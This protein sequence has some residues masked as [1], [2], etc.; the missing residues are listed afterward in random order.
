PAHHFMNFKVIDEHGRQLDMGR[1][2]G[3]LRAELGGQARESFQ[4]LA[5]KTAQASEQGGKS[6]AAPSRAASGNAA[7]SSNAQHQNL[8]GWTF[9]ELPELLEIQRGKQTLI[10]FPALVDRKTHCDIEVFDDPD[11]A[12]RIHR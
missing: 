3:V 11:E 7:A 4:R 6:A 2:L 8:T 5:E 1:N 12:A 10:G 9:G